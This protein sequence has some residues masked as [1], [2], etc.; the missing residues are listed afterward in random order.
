M[1]AESLDV[2]MT[3]DIA[4]P[5]FEQI[6]HLLFKHR[7]SQLVSFCKHHVICSHIVAVMCSIIVPTFEQICNLLFKHRPSQLVSFL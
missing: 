1:T 6:C 5:M 2:A 3:C 4:V 7:P